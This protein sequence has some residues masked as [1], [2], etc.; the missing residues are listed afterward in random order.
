MHRVQFRL[1]STLG[2]VQA[3]NSQ[4]FWKPGDVSLVRLWDQSFGLSSRA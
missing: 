4:A 3:Q 1:A 2:P